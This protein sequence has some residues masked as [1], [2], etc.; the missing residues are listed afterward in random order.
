[1]INRHQ[2]LSKNKQYVP[3]DSDLNVARLLSN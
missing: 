2:F 3:G 1:M